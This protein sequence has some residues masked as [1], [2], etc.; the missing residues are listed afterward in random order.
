[1]RVARHALHELPVDF[2]E[3]KGQVL[4][5]IKRA[6]TAAEIIERKTAADIAHLVDQA[7][8]GLHVGDRAGFGDFED[9]KARVDRILPKQSLEE[10]NQLLGVEGLS[11]QV[12]REGGVLTAVVQSGE[13]M[14]GAP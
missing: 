11:R 3:V 13:P 6:E 5:M 8:G 4:Q 7:L 12:D 10:R 9:Q 14:Q 1:D 2:N